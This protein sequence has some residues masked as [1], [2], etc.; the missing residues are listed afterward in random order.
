MKKLLLAVAAVGALFAIA[1]ASAFAAGNPSPTGT[2]QP[3]QTCLVTAPLEPGNAAS[4]AAIIAVT[5]GARTRP[6][7]L[8]CGRQ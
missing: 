6:R 7:Q 5:S 4:A 8:G 3:S 2:G 1:V